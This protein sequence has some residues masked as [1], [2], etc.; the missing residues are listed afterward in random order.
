MGVETTVAKLPACD[1]CG[2][3]A[4]YDGKTKAGPWAYM[5][6]P[7]WKAHGVGKLGTGFAQRLV[8]EKP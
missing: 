2:S 8:E 3:T 6:E 5:C 7:C 4:S 1:L